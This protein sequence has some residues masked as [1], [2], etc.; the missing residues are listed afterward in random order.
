MDYDLNEQQHM[1]QEAAHKFL[2]KECPSEFVRKMAEDERGF[3]DE[4]WKG[5]TDLGWMSLLVPEEYGGFGG[6]FLDLAVLLSEMGYFALPGPYFSTVVLGGLTLLEAGNEEQKRE[7]LPELS[8]GKRFLT[9]AWVEKEGTFSPDGIQTKADAAGNGY[10]LSGTKLFV[11]DAHVADPI[12]CAAR[13]GKDPEQ[14]TLF[15]VD[16]KTQGVTI[17]PLETMAGDK[18][19]EVVL[20]NA[21]IPAEG[22]LG[23]VDGAWPVLRKVQMLAAVAKCAEMAGGARKAMDLVLPW[24]KERIQFGRPIGS[25]QAVQHHCAN[26]LTY[27]DTL[28]LMTYKA[29]WRISA[30]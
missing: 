28:T 10:V 30:G 18:Q 8:Q 12:I 27:L 5:M 13:T 16:P 15:L 26:M 20:E 25:F 1:I 3:T 24:T 29:A 2:S 22:V 11:P 7:M 9:L 14:V 21:E 17:S 19:F 6:D 23:E 4:L